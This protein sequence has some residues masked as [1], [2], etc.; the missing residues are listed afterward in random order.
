M[1]FTGT[2][3]R[4]ELHRVALVGVGPAPCRACCR[5]LRVGLR[6]DHP[7]SRMPTGEWSRE[8]KHAPPLSVAAHD[9]TR[10]RARAHAHARTRFT[11]THA[12]RARTRNHKCTHTLAR[13][14]RKPKH[15]TASSR[16]VR[17]AAHARRRSRASNVRSHARG[18]RRG[19]VC[20]EGWGGG[21]GGHSACALYTAQPS[22]AGGARLGLCHL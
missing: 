10:T 11:R 20:V 14:Q 9:H 12:P 1:R 2:A 18:A 21:G 16:A 5:R 4:P 22:S 7:H 19:C 15:A 13:V 3:G 8:R 17:H 6:V